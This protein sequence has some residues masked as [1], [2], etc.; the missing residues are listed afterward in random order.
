MGLDMYLHSVEK[1][2]QFVYAKDYLVNSY[3]QLNNIG[4]WR[5]QWLIHNWFVQYIQNGNDD[6]QAYF[7]K[8]ESLENLKRICEEALNIPPF[9]PILFSDHDNVFTT[10]H[11]NR[12]ANETIETINKALKEFDEESHVLI[13]YSFW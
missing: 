4:Y 10:S 8:K 6:C 1:N 5:E 3:E 13:Y 12:C 2:N 9:A 11:Y 7:V